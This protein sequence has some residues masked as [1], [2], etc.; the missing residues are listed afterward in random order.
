MG[1]RGPQSHP[2][3]RAPHKNARGNAVTRKAEVTENSPGYWDLITGNN[4]RWANPRC[5]ERKAAW[6]LWRDRLTSRFAWWCQS[7][8]RFAA[9]WAFD[10]EALASAAGISQTELNAMA[11]TEI[12]YRLTDSDDERGIIEHSWRREIEHSKQW[13]PDHWREYATRPEF[14][15]PGWFC[16]SVISE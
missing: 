15:V 3:R 11:C 7:G 2:T 13:H 5:K 9:W 8:N 6:L 4:Q 10:M 16:D 14:G 12:V 1:A